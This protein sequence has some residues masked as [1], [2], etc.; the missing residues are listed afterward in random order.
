MWSNRAD[1]PLRL[2]IEFVWMRRNTAY[3]HYFQSSDTLGSYR[4][5]TRY[6]ACLAFWAMTL[7]TYILTNFCFNKSL[8]LP[9]CWHIDFLSRANACS[10]L[11]VAI[12]DH[13]LLKQCWSLLSYLTVVSIW[14]VVHLVFT[15]IALNL[16]MPNLALLS[17]HGS[18]Y[19][20]C[21]ERRRELYLPFV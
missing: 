13:N 3:S 16:I 11:D 9:C 19:S 5:C 2:A 21:E 14:Y 8:K 20:H 6:E 4:L 1:M 12:C 15:I 7:E 17:S 18:L 10:T